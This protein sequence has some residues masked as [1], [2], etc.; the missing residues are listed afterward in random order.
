MR[1]ASEERAAV[2]RIAVYMERELPR[3][4]DPET[5][6]DLT[7]IS[8]HFRRVAGDVPLLELAQDLKRQAAELG[9][10]GEG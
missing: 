3:V 2:G 8:R 5:R 9:P 10:R 4:T 1:L 6:E 7:A